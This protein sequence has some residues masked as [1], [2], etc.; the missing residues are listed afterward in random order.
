MST[1]KFAFLVSVVGIFLLPS[2]CG[3][4]SP[5]LGRPLTPEEIQKIDIT[6]ATDGRGLPPGSG[7]VSAGVAV[8]AK[9]CQSC[10]G[11]DLK[12][13]RGPAVEDAVKL[14]KEKYCSV[15][16]MLEKAAAIDYEIVFVDG[17]PEP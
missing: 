1:P 6:V 9:S 8:Y 5:N 10:H 12:G 11:P 15:S 7:S 14:S 2:F 13:D 17:E 4:Q 16:L 3:A